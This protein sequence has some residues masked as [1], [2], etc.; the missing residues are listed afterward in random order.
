MTVQ[1]H[2][3]QSLNAISEKHPKASAPSVCVTPSVFFIQ[4]RNLMFDKLSF[5]FQ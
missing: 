4:L 5:H 2:L 3:H 1:L